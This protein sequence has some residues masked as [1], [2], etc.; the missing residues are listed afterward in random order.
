MREGG[1]GAKQRR[2]RQSGRRENVR[3]NARCVYVC[4][5]GELTADRRQ[6]RVHAAGR[7]HGGCSGGLV[8]AA[9][10]GS[11]TVELAGVTD[12]PLQGPSGG[13]QIGVLGGTTGK[14]KQGKAREQN[15]GVLQL[16]GLVRRPI[17]LPHFSSW[18]RCRPSNIPPSASC[19]QS[20]HPTPPPCIPPH[21]NISTA[22]LAWWLGR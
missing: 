11:A 4:V 9:C 13:G 19:R 18:S 5:G 20:E 10:S 8:G 6:P 3:R 1:R 14:A 21:L 22:R 12:D 7:H 17:T 16:R 2:T 15:V